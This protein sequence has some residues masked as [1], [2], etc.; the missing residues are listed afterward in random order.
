MKLKHTRLMMVKFA[1]VVGW[2][3]VG[4]SAIGALVCAI[5]GTL[6]PTGKVRRLL[7]ECGITV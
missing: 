6:K 3:L 1:S 2:V 7:G 4:V 5:G